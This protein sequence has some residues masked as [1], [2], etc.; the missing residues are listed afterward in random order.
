M[1]VLEI[2]YN[3]LPIC[4][5]CSKNY[6][7]KDF[8]STHTLYKVVKNAHAKSGFSVLEIGVKVPSCRRCSKLPLKGLFTFGIPVFLV[9]FYVFYSMIFYQNGVNT[10]FDVNNSEFLKFIF[11]FLPSLL[12]GY[13]AFRIVNKIITKQLY[14]YI[15][16]KSHFHFYHVI[17]DLKN[18]GW[19][20]KKPDLDKLNAKLVKGDLG[21][22]IDLIEKSKSIV[23]L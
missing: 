15:R 20:V 13:T 11:S 14:G 2:D 6:A 17:M 23:K 1:E 12:I 4:H 10:I 22:P 21:L 16:P 19:L 3:G 5:H 9:S 8:E 7:E 18:R